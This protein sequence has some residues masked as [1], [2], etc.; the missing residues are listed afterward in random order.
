MI[1]L[2]RGAS[3][4]PT[5]IEKLYVLVRLLVSLFGGTCSVEWLTQQHQYHR[6]CCLY[7][8]SWLQ[9]EMLSILP[10]SRGRVGNRYKVIYLS[11]VSSNDHLDV[12]IHSTH[13]S[14]GVI[15]VVLCTFLQRFIG[16]ITNPLGFRY[17]HVP[18]PMFTLSMYV[19]SPYSWCL[20]LCVGQPVKC[21][22]WHIFVQAWSSHTS[23]WCRIIPHQ[24]KSYP[25]H[26]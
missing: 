19:V 22:Y 14:S 4:S 26:P 1:T 25:R 17:L 6:S 9:N 12:V 3:F 15:C 18:S 7:P 24:P 2:L 20:Y 5:S 11:M 21:I 13:R 23:D 10:P 16:W 8:G